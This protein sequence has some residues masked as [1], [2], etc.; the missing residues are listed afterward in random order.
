MGTAKCVNCGKEVFEYAA[1]CPYCKKPI[2]NPHAPTKIANAPWTWKK[3]S[4]GKKAPY[5]IIAVCLAAAI[6]AAIVL[7]LVL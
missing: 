6:I 5:G 3:T 4:Y 2:A 1:E 7:Y